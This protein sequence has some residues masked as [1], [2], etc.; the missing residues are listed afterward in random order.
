M[1]ESVCANVCVAR[2]LVHLQK[3]KVSQP[4]N[5]ASAHNEHLF[6][7]VS[8]KWSKKEEKKEN[9]KGNESKKEKNAWG[10]R[11]IKYE[12]MERSLCTAATA[13]KIKTLI[14]L[15]LLAPRYIWT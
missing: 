15:L 9:K 10:S 8:H 11:G 13:K 12:L 3:T 7:I 14:K 1:H 2:P 6:V 4:H 5:D